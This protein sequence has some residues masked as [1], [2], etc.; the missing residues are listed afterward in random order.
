[1]VT[2]T[3]RGAGMGNGGLKGSDSEYLW[4]VDLEVLV[5]FCFFLGSHSWHTEVPRLGMELEL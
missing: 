4:K 1:M 2:Q 5:L 3:G